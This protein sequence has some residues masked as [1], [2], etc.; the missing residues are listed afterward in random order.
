MLFLLAFIAFPLSVLGGQGSGKIVSFTI[1][2]G[3]IIMFGTEE[4]INKPSCSSVSEF[5]INLN[6]K[7]GEMMAKSLQDAVENNLSV[8]VEGNGS[9]I[10]WGDRETP[11]FLRII[12]NTGT[13]SAS[14]P[15]YWFTA[16]P[17]YVGGCRTVCNEGTG[18]LPVA[19]KDGYVC[20]SDD[21]KLGTAI[22]RGTYV[23]NN[24]WSCLLNGES[25]GKLAQCYCTPID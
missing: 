6:S 24:S 25:I 16:S 2:E 11:L 13:V 15:G 14:L 9:C 22:N 8:Y 3:D 17:V 4:H 19:D 7:T 21:H 20:K 12:P 5:A 10:S 23:Y 1:H 18:Y